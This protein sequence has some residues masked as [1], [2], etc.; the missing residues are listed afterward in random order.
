MQCFDADI[1]KQGPGLRANRGGNGRNLRK[2]LR[3]GGEIKSAAAGKDGKF[4][5]RM[6]LS[7]RP[8]RIVGI[9]AHGIDFAR[10]DMAVEQ[11]R[12]ASTR[13]RIGLRRQNRRFAID[14]HGIGIDHHAADMLGQG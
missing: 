8:S 3:Q 6:G 11:M 12:H 1:G 2:T 10:G 5:H 13:R 9:A 7:Q 4:L 14:L